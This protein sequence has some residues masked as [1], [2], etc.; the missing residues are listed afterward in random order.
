MPWLRTFPSSLT[1]RF[2]SSHASPVGRGPAPSAPTEGL[3]RIPRGRAGGEL[4]STCILRGLIGWIVKQ[5]TVTRREWLALPEPV[6]PPARGPTARSS[7]IWSGVEAVSLT[8]FYSSQI[9]RSSLSPSFCSVARSLSYARCHPTLR[10]SRYALAPH[11]FA[12]SLSPSVAN[13]FPPPH[14]LRPP[15]PPSP[16]PARPGPLS[17]S[18]RPSG[19]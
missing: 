1:V 15:A 17:R 16:P 2:S 8:L 5:G 9:N 19:R 14:R 18:P 6:P 11:S 7:L 3:L 12:P 13:A 4:K 10:S